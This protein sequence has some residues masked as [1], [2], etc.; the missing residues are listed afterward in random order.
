M[1]L[2]IK[3]DT[4]LSAPGAAPKVADMDSGLMSLYTF[5][6][7]GLADG[8]AV[9]SVAS[10]G[11]TRAATLT[12]PTAPP[13]V[14][15]N[16]VNGHAVLDF[17]RASSQKIRSALFATEELQPVTLAVVGRR[18]TA[19]AVSGIFL[20]GGVVSAAAHNLSIESEST[21]YLAR[22]NSVDGGNLPLGTADTGWHLYVYVVNTTS[23]R[24]HIDGQSIAGTITA[25]A[26]NTFPRITVGCN[27]SGSANFLDG[28]IA[29]IREYSRALSVPDV[30]KLRAV[31]KAK[32]ALP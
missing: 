28:Q 5:D 11:G 26:L 8:A 7:L 15:L 4:A 3:S 14:K 6:S 17:T 23:S 9:T 30:A 1:T 27:A 12:E 20:S 18:K 16:T 10:T 22:G 31:L 19:A 25:S 24:F 2:I 21:A 32:Y 29:E 13:V